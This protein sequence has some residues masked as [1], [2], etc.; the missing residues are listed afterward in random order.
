MM[1]TILIICLIIVATVYTLA[2]DYY[3]RKVSWFLLSLVMVTVV[4]LEHGLEFGAVLFV[5]TILVYF[6][7]EL[8]NSS[9]EPFWKRIKES[10]QMT[11]AKSINTVILSLLI[12]VVTVILYKKRPVNE[13]ESMWANDHSNVLTEI[14]LGDISLMV[15]TLAIF[16]IFSNVTKEKK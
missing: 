11:K 2:K 3:S 15:L 7:S 5:S 14:S 9:N 8:L 12:G 16:Y 6:I 4:V 10:E 13:V 1:N